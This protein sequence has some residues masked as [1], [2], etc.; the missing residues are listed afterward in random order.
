[1]RRYFFAGRY[2]GD[3]CV[4][5]ATGLSPRRRH[6]EKEQVAWT[7]FYCEMVLVQ[8]WLIIGVQL[9]RSSSRPHPESLILLCHVNT[10]N[11]CERCEALGT[12]CSE[13][14]ALQQQ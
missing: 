14:G 8:I 2:E 9:A 4:A 5:V 7:M 13:E 11:Q 1:M 6:A 3:S 12:E 10:S